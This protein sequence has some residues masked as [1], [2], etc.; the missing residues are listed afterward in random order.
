MVNAR[1][2]NVLEAKIS[3]K[4]HFFL[5]LCAISKGA[6]LKCV[7]LI[8]ELNFVFDDDLYWIQAS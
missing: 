3:K 4:F 2:S 1:I 8:F 7:W 6:L 5:N